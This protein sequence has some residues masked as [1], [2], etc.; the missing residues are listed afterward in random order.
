MTGD[1]SP[2]T[3]SPTANDHEAFENLGDQLSDFCR[4]AH[5][6]LLLAAPYITKG[7]LARALYHVSG[8]FPVTIVTRW[9]VEELAAGVSD[10][11]IWEIITADPRSRLLLRP[12]LHAKYYRADQRCLV[13]SANITSKALGWSVSSNFELLLPVS[14]AVLAQFEAHL[15]EGTSIVDETVVEAMQVALAAFGPPPEGAQVSHALPTWSDDA[16]LP[17]PALWIPQLRTPEQLF[18]AYSG[19]WDAL[20]ATGRV[21]ARRDLEILD[22]PAGLSRLSFNALVGARLLQFPS[23]NSLDRFLVERRRFGAVREYLRSL[24]IAHGLDYDVSAAWQTIM[25]WLLYFLPGRYS[26]SRPHHTELF[27]RRS[28]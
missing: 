4:K 23:I 19:Q 27:G 6:E 5:T 26:Y 8:S 11:G 14:A 25:R 15:L 13:G 10:L 18:I 9:R 17:R 16:A 21:A 12:D 7:A 1:G 2:V 3:S 28:G 24:L 22:L 20:T